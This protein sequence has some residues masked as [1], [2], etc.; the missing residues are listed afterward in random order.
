MTSL[1]SIRK[2]INTWA[3][4]ALSVFIVAWLSLIIAPCMMAM[5][6]PT[7]HMAM[8]SHSS[9]MSM[10]DQS[11]SDESQEVSD[12]ESCC[13]D[14]CPR[15]I[16]QDMDMSCQTNDLNCS[17]FDNYFT[18]IDQTKVKNNTSNNSLDDFELSPIVFNTIA[19]DDFRLLNESIRSISPLPKPLL[20]GTP[21]N[22]RYCVYL[23]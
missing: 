7:E 14:D 12:K 18:Q 9:H 11:A 17:D 8:D 15:S 6:A 16:P 22:V 23:I 5:D 21:I 20:S 4:S 19:V 1:A 3:N 13:D 10:V 2:Q